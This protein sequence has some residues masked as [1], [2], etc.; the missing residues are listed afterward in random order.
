LRNHQ[1]FNVANCNDVSAAELVPANKKIVATHWYVAEGNQVNKEPAAKVFKECPNGG[2]CPIGWCK[3]E[4][5]AAGFGKF[6]N[7]SRDYA[8]TA[9]IVADIANK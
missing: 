8:R 6:K 7:W 1:C 4:G 5:A 9:V 2:A 3:W